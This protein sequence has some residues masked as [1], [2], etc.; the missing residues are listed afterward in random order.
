MISTLRMEESPSDAALLDRLAG[1]GRPEGLLGWEVLCDS[2]GRQRMELITRWTS[3]EHFRTWLSSPACARVLGPLGEPLGHRLLRRVETPGREVPWEHFT[4]DAGP[5]VARHL[6]ESDVTC[7]LAAD[8]EGTIRACNA[9]LAARLRIP[10]EQLPGRPLFDLLTD[11]D[12]DLVRLKIRSGELAGDVF[13]LNF[14]APAGQAPLTLA[15]RLGICQGRLMLIGEP[16]GDDAALQGEFLRLNHELATLKRD[17]LRK[18]KDLEEALKVIA[19][20]VRTD[21]LTG[22][23]NRRH[24]QEFLGLEM[25]LVARRKRTLCAL[26]IDLDHFKSVN[27]SFGHAVGDLVLRTA[28]GVIA[29]QVRAC[30]LAARVGGEEFLVLMPD[31]ELASAIIAAERV[32]LAIGR[33]TVLECPWQITASIGAAQAQPGEPG[34]DFLERA[35]RALYR[36]KAGGRNRVE[37]DPPPGLPDGPPA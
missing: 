14:L 29:S 24:S 37:C 5:L 18:G 31:T 9:A 4:P 30:D 11:F 21:H 26:M 27:D 13:L 23:P 6:A 3:E 32:R 17:N 16:P 10:A 7:W 8:P 20:I 34:E 1:S 19:Q 25:A 28:A 35:D 36:A 33:S 12:A 22:L 2:P 15:C